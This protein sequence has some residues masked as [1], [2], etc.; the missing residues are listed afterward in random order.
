MKLRFV[1]ADDAAFVREIVK[2]LLESD[3]HL[4]V[5]E[6]SNGE[7]ALQVVAATL[8]DLL[9]SDLVMPSKSGLH[10][11]KAVRETYPVT[12]IIACSTLDDQ[13]NINRAYAV[14]SDA[15]IVKPF[16]AQDFRSTIKKLFSQVKEVTNE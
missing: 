6:A 16:Q 3:G 7:E 2:N 8:P 4:C 11:I 1:V 10:T 9:I 13:T 15:Y 14:G 12:K 5:G